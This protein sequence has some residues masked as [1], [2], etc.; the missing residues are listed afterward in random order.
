MEC[1]CSFLSKVQ[2]LPTVKSFWHTLPAGHFWVN[3][4][5]NILS[6][7]CLQIRNITRYS[8]FR[9]FTLIL[10]LSCDKDDKV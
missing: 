10:L 1:F 3:G 5:I 8:I 6:L 7:I 4:K 9:T 2:G